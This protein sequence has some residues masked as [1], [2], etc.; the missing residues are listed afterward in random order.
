MT[1]QERTNAALAVMNLPK[2]TQVLL[3]I[4]N[5]KQQ[6]I[7]EDILSPMDAYVKLLLLN[8]IQEMDVEISVG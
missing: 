2:E 6:S 5:H 4:V 8:P 3:S 1:Q 7:T